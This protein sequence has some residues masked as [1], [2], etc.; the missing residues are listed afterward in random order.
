MLCDL[1]SCCEATGQPS[2]WGGF[3]RISREPIDASQSLKM[4]PLPLFLFNQNRTT[5]GDP[6]TA[7]PAR[8][9]PRAAGF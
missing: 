7:E 2:G 6:E 5:V 4:S 3:P 8:A 1:K 9:A